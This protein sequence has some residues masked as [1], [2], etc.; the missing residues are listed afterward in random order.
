MGWRMS[1]WVQDLGGVCY[2]TNK[3]KRK[4]KYTE[5]EDNGQL[6]NIEIIVCE[7]N[8]DNTANLEIIF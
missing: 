7:I 4:E 1:S 3:K 2:L 5:L 6:V 8:L